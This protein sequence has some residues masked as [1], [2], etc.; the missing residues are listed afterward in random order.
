MS[1]ILKK[2]VKRLMNPYF[3][4]TLVFV[5]WVGIVDPFNIFNQYSLRKRVNELKHQ[6]EYYQNEI[7]HDSALLHVLE[8][9]PDSL[10]KFAR[11]E[12]LMKKDNEEIFLV[13]E[14]D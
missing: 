14:E 2:I 11:E 4:V 5:V 12:Y 8:T 1:G 6:K 10:E 13:I 9:Y 3:S 7:S